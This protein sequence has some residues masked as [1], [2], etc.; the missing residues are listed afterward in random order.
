MHILHAENITLSHGGGTVFAGLSW[1][2]GDRDRVGLVG[3]NGAGK[4]TLIR[5][6]AGDL[7]P[8]SGH[9]AT[10]GTVRIG[11]LPQDI[12]LPDG[13]TVLSCAAILPPR[14]AALDADLTQIESRLADPTVYN[15]ERKLARTLEQQ[16]QLLDQYD[17][18]GMNN[19]DARVKRIL[20]QLGFT[21]SHHALPVDA[22]S[23]GQKK[24]L[25]LARLA[26]EGPDLLLLDEPD[27]HLDISAKHQLERFING[28]NGAVVLISHDRY[29]LDEVATHI[30]ELENG[31]LTR[32][33]GNYSRY[34][35]ERELAR[36]RQEQQYITQQKQ[37][38]KIEAAI[39][40]FELWAKMTEDTRHIRQARHRRKML[41]RMAENGEMVEQVTEQRL[42]DLTLAGRR[43]SKQALKVENLTVVFDDNPVFMGV[44]FLVRHGER[45]GLIG[46]N[47]AG[48]SVLFK[49]VLG[50]IP[51][52]EGAVTVGNS[53]EV[54]YYAQ[55]HQTLEAYLQRTPIELVQET[56]PMS[57][58]AAVSVLLKFAFD[59]QQSR[60]RIATMSGGERSRLQLLRLM[61]SEPNLLLLDEP[62]NNL[63]MRSVD[64]LEQQLDAF[65][66]AVLVISHDRYFL[67][68]VVDRVLDLNDG[69]LNET[70]GGYT[71][72]LDKQ[73]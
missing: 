30:M 25:A 27:N 12:T 33:V 28:Y 42:M 66:G 23:G 3:P 18:L 29:L 31:K 64:V 41:D 54:G 63:D 6:L 34:T 40:R 21:E 11:Y 69:E 1:S 10:V 71:D 46:P 19:F 59:Y 62:T 49:A 20:A 8:D 24:L 4:S 39:A 60:Q 65:D 55:E 26:L 57:E 32:Y 47:G 2:V 70:L 67:D 72:Y 61:L 35:T 50:E 68:Q 43:G 22:L 17:R 51:P 52:F 53:T 38:A 45:V 14:L 44:S 73:Q 58:G 9:V 13:E 37:I 36:L 5:I 15:D 7:T 56:R 16:E 48:K